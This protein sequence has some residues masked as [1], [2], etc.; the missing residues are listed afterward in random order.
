MSEQD[1][2]MW[3]DCVLSDHI[4][5]STIASDLIR[6]CQTTRASCR[7][8]LNEVREVINVWGDFEEEFQRAC[9]DLKERV[10]EDLARKELLKK[11]SYVQPS[12][13][14]KITAVNKDGRAPRFERIVSC[15]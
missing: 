15:K 12:L 10:E 9:N 1:Y 6:D 7:K 4:A 13:R 8:Q 3:K 2:E 14:R 5:T 11:R